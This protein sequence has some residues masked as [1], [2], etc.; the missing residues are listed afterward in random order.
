M[1]LAAWRRERHYLQRPT[2]PTYSSTVAT[3]LS[4]KPPGIL[5]LQRRGGLS[6]DRQHRQRESVQWI[7]AFCRSQRRFNASVSGPVPT[8]SR[9]RRRTR[10]NCRRS[11]R[12]RDATF[13][14]AT[15]LTVNVV[16]GRDKTTPSPTTAGFIEEDPHLLHQPQLHNQPPAG[17]LPTAASGIV[18]TFGT[19]FHTSYMPVVAAG[20]TGRF[21]RIGPERRWC[22]CVCDVGNGVCRPG[23]Q[24]TPLDPATVYLDPT[25][26]TTS[27]SCPATPPTRSRTRR[28]FWAMQLQSCGHGWAAP[29]SPACCSGIV[30]CTA[31]T[32][33]F[34]AT[35][36]VV[37]QPNPFPP[38]KLS[39]FVSRTTSRS[40]VEHDSGG[41]IDVLAPVE[42]GLAASTSPLD[43]AGGTGDATAD[44]LTTCSTCRCRTAWRERSIRR[45]DLMPARIS[46]AN[47]NLG[48]DVRESDSITARSSPCRSYESDGQTLSPLAGQR[49][50]QPD[51]GT[52]RLVATPGA[53][54]IARARSGCRPTRWTA[55]RRTIRSC[56]SASRA[57]PGVRPRIP[58]VDRLPTRR[59]SMP[60]KYVCN[61]PTPH[62]GAN[63]N[64]R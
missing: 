9:S 28:L 26:R 17:G 56:A 39:V 57:L 5:C 37:V 27:R 30:V 25:K 6:A 55:R 49:D 60:P 31:T 48:F 13:P 41:G 59:S 34:P 54:R 8:A 61:A 12:D 15:G 40:T 7:D 35:V 16:D 18:P 32:G 36:N 1:L 10:R 23:P 38:S 19:N 33:A 21:L 46:G 29:R 11:R 3:T 51:A 64:I 47:Q 62:H 53:D 24:Q 50:L 52:L 42:P 14:T 43:D 22:S 20:C 2:S 63:C 58:R 4:I 44:D 45:L